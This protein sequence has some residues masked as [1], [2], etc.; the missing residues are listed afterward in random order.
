MTKMELADC[1]VNIGGDAGNQVPKVAI[2]PAEIAILRAIH[3]EDSVHTVRPLEL[4]DRDPHDEMEALQAFYGWKEENAKLIQRVFPAVAHMPLRLRELRLPEEYF[5]AVTRAT[6]V[7]AAEGEASEEEV[8][9]AAQVIAAKS[10]PKTTKEAL[11]E[12]VAAPPGGDIFA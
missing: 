12:A 1:L 9:T 6:P 8:E 3:G 5:A 7:D 4:V 11:G 2:T 10:P